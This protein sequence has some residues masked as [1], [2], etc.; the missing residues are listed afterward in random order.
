MASTLTPIGIGVRVWGQLGSHSGS[1]PPDVLW[2]HWKQSWPAVDCGGT[3][4]VITGVVHAFHSLPWHPHTGLIFLLFS[5]WF[6]LFGMVTPLFNLWLSS[7]RKEGKNLDRWS[8]RESSEAS[9]CFSMRGWRIEKGVFIAFHHQFTMFFHHCIQGGR[10]S[11]GRAGWSIGNI[12]IFSSDWSIF[13]IMFIVSKERG[14]LLGGT[15]HREGS[16]AF[17]SLFSS[18]F[19]LYHTIS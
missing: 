14:G 15:E 19:T 17:C 11:I 7:I 16:E 10:R 2:F 6:I 3:G 8:I 18:H 4:P 13:L 5:S 1:V 9:Y 12:W